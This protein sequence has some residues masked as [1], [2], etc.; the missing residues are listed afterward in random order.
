MTPTPPFISVC[1]VYQEDITACLSLLDAWG[2]P[3]TYELNDSA[4]VRWP[5]APQPEDRVIYTILVRIDYEVKARKVL[6]LKVRK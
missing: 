6:G 1:S 3:A 5:H 4:Q 2:I